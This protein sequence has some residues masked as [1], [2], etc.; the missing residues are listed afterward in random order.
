[1]TRLI[2]AMLWVAMLALPAHA[3]GA[4]AGLADATVLIVRHGEKPD[5]GTGLSPAGE[6][7]AKAYVHYFQPLRL[8]DGTNFRPDVLVASADSHNSARERLTL[9]PLGEALNLPIDQRFADKDVKALV[10]ALSSE[11]HGK[12]ILI[13]W[14]HGEL[15][16]LIKAFGA[17]PDALLPGGKWPGDVFD[18][19]VVLRFD[20]AGKLIPGSEHIM[21]E[22]LAD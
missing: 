14:H 7:R 9:T 2:L 18:W 6:A 8:D 22:K 1:M 19:V 21:S 16:K 13:A 11:S 4:T 10:K 17:D 5:S 20:Q 3:G 15:A 12:S